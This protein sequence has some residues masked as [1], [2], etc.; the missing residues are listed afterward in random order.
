M[1]TDK[2]INANRE[3]AQHS[4]GPIT[5]EGKEASS[6]NRFKHGLCGR[7]QMIEGES[8]TDYGRLLEW[9]LAEH[10]PEDTEEV[11]L[12]SKMAEHFW[13]AQRAQVLQNDTLRNADYPGGY[14]YMNRQEQ[15]AQF[16]LYMRYA[17]SHERGFHKCQEKLKKIRKERENRQNGFERLKIQQA[18]EKRKQELHE[19]KMAA[20]I[21]AETKAGGSQIKKNLEK[22]PAQRTQIPLDQMEDAL[23]AKLKSIRDEKTPPKAA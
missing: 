23:K 7:F 10:P 16:A 21:A 22:I 1:S 8:Q 17:S 9:F 2:Q 4:T 12:V 18:E 11:A 15:N 14:N 6:F 20:A 3:N 13:L 19:L 5:E